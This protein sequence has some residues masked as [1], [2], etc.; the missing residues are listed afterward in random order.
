MGVGWCNTNFQVSVAF[1]TTSGYNKLKAFLKPF[2]RFLRSSTGPPLLVREMRRFASSPLPTYIQLRVLAMTLHSDRSSDESKNLPP[3]LPH[4]GAG[5][6]YSQN[7]LKRSEVPNEILGSS[8]VFDEGA[9]GEEALDEKPETEASL[10]HVRRVSAQVTRTQTEANFARFLW[11]SMFTILIL[12]SPYLARQLAYQITYG[13]QKAEYDIASENLQEAA[14]K[15]GDFI[16]VSRLIVKKISPSLV[17][18]HRPNTSRGRFRGTEG[19]GSGVIVDR[20]GYIFTNYHVIAGASTVTIHLNDGRVAEAK[21]IGFD[22]STDLALLLLKKKLPDLVAAE[23]GDSEKLQVGDPVWA[24][25]SPFGLDQSITQGIVSAKE[26]RTSSR[27]SGRPLTRNNYQE[28]LQTDAAVNPGNSGGP[29]VNILGQVVG[30]NTAI[31]GDS[32]QGVSFAIPSALA[33][34]KYLQL[35]EHGYVER[36]FLGVKPM[37]VPAR[38]RLELELNPKEG[39]YVGSVEPGTPAANGKLR[40]GDVLLQWDDY[41]ATDPG[42]LSRKIAA[43][44]IGATVQVLV[45]RRTRTQSNQIVVKELALQVIVGRRTPDPDTVLRSQR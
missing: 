44:K 35:R 12:A 26:R 11:V 43:T 28:Y 1:I 41:L 36:G 30:I 21:V 18:I 27:I 37:V 15:L 4:D 8:H 20:E 25:G 24:A 17:S 3:K 10:L 45:L 22:E 2:E 16:S 23:W 32:F 31:I 13:E 5:A 19:Q 40:Q 33:Q 29:L 42:L 34:E 6:F 9:F 38:I 39:V 7:G 14:L